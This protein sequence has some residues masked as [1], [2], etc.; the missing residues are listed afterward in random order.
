MTNSIHD[1]GDAAC[2]LA[3]GT[4]T[5]ATH[6]VI[7]V[8]VK[9]ATGKGGK[10][11]VANPREISLVRISDLWLSERPG[12]DVALLMGM[13]RVIVDEGLADSAFIEKRCE[14]FE[15]FKTS[16]KNFDLDTVERITGVPKAKVAE[17]ARMYATNKPAAILYAMGI[18]QHSHGTDNVLAVAN[19]AMLT[20]NI[21]K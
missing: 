7:G 4:N 18:T 20:G 10:L 9:R 3:I 16:L 17:A 12:T 2:I 11:I 5:S 6:P 19:L 13:A 14:N 8:E 21:G 15:A 1:I